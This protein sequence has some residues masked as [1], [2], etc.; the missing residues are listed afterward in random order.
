[1]P[2]VFLARHGPSAAAPRGFLTAAQFGD[3]LRGYDD[4]GL[5]AATVAPAELMAAAA[6]S[7][8]IVHSPLRRSVDTVRLLDAAGLSRPRQVWP[9]LVEAAQPAPSV[10][11]FRLPLG[12]W[13]VVTRVRWLLGSPGSVE[14]RAVAVARAGVV[15]ERLGELAGVVLVVGHG[16]QNIL[17]ARELRRRGWRGT[18]WPDLR[19]GMPTAYQRGLACPGAT[20]RR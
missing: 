19:H 17:I 3:H 14:P 12:G 20:E 8:V 16:F 4:V 2:I 1:V 15:A 9:E 18:R 11:G 7:D 10:G 13:D 6:R 5:A